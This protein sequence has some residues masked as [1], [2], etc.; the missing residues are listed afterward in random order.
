VLA[1][2]AER[3]HVFGVNH[4]PAYPSYRKFEADGGKAGT[5]ELN[6][7][8]WVPLFERHNVD[9]VLE[10]HDHTFKRTHPLKDGLTNA[11]GIIYLGDGSWGK[12]R[13]PARPDQRPYLAASSE[14][15]HM[16]LHRLEGEQRFHVALEETGRI[17]DICMTRK[18]P[19]RIVG[20]S[21]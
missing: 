8:H 14:S 18:R 9:L 19:R 17:V 3:P 4:V 15:Y 5:G 10:H 20:R 2:R 13:P 11:N 1:E 16:T 6:R 21:G 12:I 7:V